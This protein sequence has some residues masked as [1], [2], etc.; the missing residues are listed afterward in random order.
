M[1]KLKTNGKGANVSVNFM[2]GSK[3][4]ISIMNCVS[5]L[6]QIIETVENNMNEDTEMGT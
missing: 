1:V 3:N 2:P 4:I 6:S 5:H